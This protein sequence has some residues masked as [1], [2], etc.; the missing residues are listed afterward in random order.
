MRT[1]II[2]AAAAIAVAGC[3]RPAE[4]PADTS[5]AD[6][7]TEAMPAESGTGTTADMAAPSSTSGSG[8]AAS[9]SGGSAMAADGAGAETS[10]DAAAMN[11]PAAGTSPISPS[12]RDGAKEKAE[13]T[14]LHPAG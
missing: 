5:M 6:G 2:C 3:Q 12:T 11:E 14:N 4:E 7:A 9:R 13:S 8:S 1:L 10:A